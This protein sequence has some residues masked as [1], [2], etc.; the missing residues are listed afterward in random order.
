MSG[1]VDYSNGSEEFSAELTLHSEVLSPE[2]FQCTPANMV[3]VHE[4]K[5]MNKESNRMHTDKEEEALI[6][7]EAILNIVENSQSFHRLSQK[8]C[9]TTVFLDSADEAMIDV[10]AGLESDGY[11]MEHHKALSHHRSLGSCRNSQNSD[12]EENEPQCEK[13]EMEL[14][15]IMSQRWDSSIEEPGPKRRSAGKNMHRSSTEE[16]S[17]SEEEME[18]S[19]SNMLLTNLSIPQLDGTADE[20]GGK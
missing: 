9:Q 14:S 15:L 3:E 5:K 19:G 11:Q 10:L 18:W 7:E 12:D 20:N 13:E 17:S 2:T 16:D 1:S 4:D 6:N 8:L